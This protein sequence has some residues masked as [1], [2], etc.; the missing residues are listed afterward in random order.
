MGCGSSTAT[1]ERTPLLNSANAGLLLFG[2]TS[3][4][5]III[6]FTHGKIETIKSTF[7]LPKYAH[8]FTNK[9]GIGYMTGG[10]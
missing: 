1:Q 5:P 3:K 8:T 7:R 2:S 10:V 6:S 4:G 9:K